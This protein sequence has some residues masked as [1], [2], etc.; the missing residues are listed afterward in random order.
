MADSFIYYDESENELAGAAASTLLSLLGLD[1]DLA[2]FVLP[3]NVTIAEEAAGFSVT[4]NAIE[5]AVE[6]ASSVNQDLTTDANPTF[7]SI[8]I[9]TGAG[10][11]KVLTSDANGAATWETSGS[12]TEAIIWAIVFGG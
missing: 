3:E 12:T 6:A 4:A 9:T 1:T 11:A 7:A 8:K 5:L 2:T 10:L